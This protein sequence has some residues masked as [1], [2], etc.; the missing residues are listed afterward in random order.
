MGELIDQMRFFDDKDLA[1]EINLTKE[2]IEY[3]YLFE[4]RVLCDNGLRQISGGYSKVTIWGGDEEIL[5]IEVEAGYD[6]TGG[7]SSRDTWQVKYNRL[8]NQIEEA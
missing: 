2:E 5:N 4:W 6:D 7:G 3:L 1:D 8:T